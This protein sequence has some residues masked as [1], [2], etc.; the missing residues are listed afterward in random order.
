MLSA[1]PP[2]WNSA[3]SLGGAIG[4][5][6]CPEGSG[7]L[8]AVLAVASAVAAA[9][10]GCASSL[11]LCSGCNDNKTSPPCS[12]PPAHA[13]CTAEAGARPQT[14]SLRRCS[15]H[16]WPHGHHCGVESDGEAEGVTQQGLVPAGNPWRKPCWLGRALCL[17]LSK[18]G[19]HPGSCHHVHGL[20]S[21]CCLAF[22]SGHHQRQGLG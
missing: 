8:S 7:R 20:Y 13:G 16:T 9:V 14:A 18:A 4:R 12:I 1:A 19:E 17:P 10:E 15:G 21:N 6:Q 3:E 22:A 2:R 5:F 11:A